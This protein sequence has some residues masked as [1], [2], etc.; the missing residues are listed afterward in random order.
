MKNMSRKSNKASLCICIF[1]WLF[2][3]N[4]MDYDICGHILRCVYDVFRDNGLSYYKIGKTYLPTPDKLRK[5]ETYII[6]FGK[7]RDIVIAKNV[8]YDDSFEVIVRDKASSEKYK[9]TFLRYYSTVFFDVCEVIFNS[10]SARSWN[11]CYRL[12]LGFL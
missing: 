12:W 5:V 3:E 6:D 9:A 7:S 4:K 1:A 8:R 11:D 2:M 10:L